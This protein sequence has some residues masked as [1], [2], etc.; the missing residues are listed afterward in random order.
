MPDACST[1]LQLANS[2]AMS[3]LH[4]CSDGSAHGDNHQVQI[5]KPTGSSV[6]AWQMSLHQAD[7]YC[8]LFS[9]ESSC[10]VQPPGLS[11]NGLTDALQR[12]AVVKL[13]KANDKVGLLQSML[14]HNLSLLMCLELRT[15]AL[16]A[17]G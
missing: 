14:P 9:L 16:Q 8:T 11:M 17:L 2:L 4:C 10:V 7:V 15:L 6:I 12:L 3:C 1:A 13:S 5:V